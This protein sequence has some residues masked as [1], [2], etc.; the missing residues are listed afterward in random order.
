MKKIFIPLVALFALTACSGNDTPLTGETGEGTLQVNISLPQTRAGESYAIA[1]NDEVKVTSLDAYLFDADGK[2]VKSYEDLMAEEWTPASPSETKTIHLEGISGNGSLLFVANAGETASL[3]S[4]PATKA[5]FE[6]LLTDA[7]ES[8]P[9]CPLMMTDEVKIENWVPG[10]TLTLNAKLT[11]VMARLDLLVWEEAGFTL[12]KA[13]LIGAS[14]K[15]YVFPNAEGFAECDKIDLVNASLVSEDV[16]GRTD[17]F[18]DYTDKR[19]KALFYLYAAPASQMTLRL[20]GTQVYSGKEA[21]AVYEIPFEKI[22]A[23]G[24]NL[25]RN[26]CYALVLKNVKVDGDG[27][28]DIGVDFEVP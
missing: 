12:E 13:E 7:L 15:S 18:G 23:E 4:V 27:K 25:D 19:Y 2:Y 3:E 28:F 22:F 5:D 24:T 1:T 26:T 11:R 20:Y 17:E 10:S 14:T 8:T 9:A 21:E 16:T 6:A